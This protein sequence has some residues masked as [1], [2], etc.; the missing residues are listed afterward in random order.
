MKLLTVLAVLL[1]AT[2]VFAGD[3]DRDK[4]QKAQKLFNSMTAT[5]ALESNKFDTRVWNTQLPGTSSWSG[6]RNICLD[7]DMIRS[8]QPYNKCVLW[9]VNLKEKKFGKDYK[10]FTYYSQASNYAEDSSNAKGRPECAESVVTEYAHP[11]NYTVNACVLWGVS[12]KEKSFGKDVKTFN[13][14][15]QANKFADDSSNAKGNPFCME[16]QD[17]QK[18]FPSTYKVD[19]F[20]KRSDKENSDKLGSYSYPWDNCDGTATMPPA[21]AN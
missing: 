12:L 17:V 18:S 19:F 8:K 5:E 1:V 4:K 3:D 9:I 15:G 13:Y 16:K 21:P 2:N 10:E 20:V 7:G 11:V 14:Y 6:P